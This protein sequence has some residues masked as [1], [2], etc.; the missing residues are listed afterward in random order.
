MSGD[1]HSGPVTIAGPVFTVSRNVHVSGVGISCGRPPPT[2]L[3]NA[4]P[5]CAGQLPLH[6]FLPIARHCIHSTEIQE[7]MTRRMTTSLE[8]CRRI[9]ESSQTVKMGNTGEN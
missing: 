7:D 5:V 4:L 3:L 1:V 8:T 6:G 9:A 2:R